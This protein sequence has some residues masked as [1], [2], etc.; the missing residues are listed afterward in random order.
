MNDWEQCPS[1]EHTTSP[2]VPIGAQTLEQLSRPTGKRLSELEE[3]EKGKEEGRGGKRKE[4]E[5]R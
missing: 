3:E 4:E 5:E 2:V 1:S